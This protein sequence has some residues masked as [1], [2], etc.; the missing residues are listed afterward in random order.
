MVDVDRLITPC[1]M[2]FDFGRI[3]KQKKTNE[4]EEK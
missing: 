4:M 1:E 2:Q 3:T